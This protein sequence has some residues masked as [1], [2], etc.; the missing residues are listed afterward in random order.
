[1]SRIPSPAVLA[2]LQHGVTVTRVAE[3]LGVS[4]GVT[5]RYLSGHTRAHP[6]LYGVIAALGSPDLASDVERLVADA[7]AELYGEAVPA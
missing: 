4:I 6:R 5:S 1:M 3:A 7:R 2:L